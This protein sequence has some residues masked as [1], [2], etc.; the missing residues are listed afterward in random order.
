MPLSLPLTVSIAASRC[1]Y[2]CLSLSAPVTPTAN[3]C[4]LGAAADYDWALL[5]HA[6]R[7]SLLYADWVHTNWQRS[8]QPPFLNKQT[9]LTAALTQLTAAPTQLVTAPKQLTAALTQL[10][11]A[12]A[13]RTL[14]AI[15]H[16]A[17]TQTAPSTNYAPQIPAHTATPTHTLIMHTL[18]C[19]HAQHIQHH[20]CARRHDGLGLLLCNCNLLS[21]YS[22]NCIRTSQVSATI[23][24]H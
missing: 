8:A 3:T 17:R 12:H 5:Q 19:I 13:P 18:T 24:T 7:E 4:P 22:A 20:Q 6:G 2:R 11:I 15:Q 16:H 10:T 21:G 1:L 23:T 14:C 9:Q